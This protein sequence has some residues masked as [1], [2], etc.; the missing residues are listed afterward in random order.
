[1]ITT[2]QFGEITAQLWTTLR[3]ESLKALGMEG[4]SC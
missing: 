1:V 4:R 3:A 2:S